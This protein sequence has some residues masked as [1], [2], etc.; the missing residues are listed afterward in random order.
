MTITRRGLVKALGISGTALSSAG[1]LAFDDTAANETPSDT[2]M[3]TETPAGTDTQTETPTATAG[4]AAE[5]PEK[6]PEVSC[7]AVSRP[8]AEPVNREGALA[9]REYPGRPP[10]ELAGEAA[11]EYATTFELAYRQNAK[12]R[13]NTDVTTD[14]ELDTYLTRFDISIQNSWVAAGPSDSVVVRLQYIG[15]GTFHYG[16]EFDYITQYVTYYVDSTRVV[17]ARTTL[18]NFEGIDALDPDPWADGNPVACFEG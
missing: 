11:V 7:E 3:Q 15:S 4:W 9:P 10:S 1:C 5:I 17:R 16:P 2:D 18:H 12:M 13:A 8:I 14:G 6:P